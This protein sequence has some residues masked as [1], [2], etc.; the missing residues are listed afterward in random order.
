MAVSDAVAARPGRGVDGDESTFRPA[1]V[2]QAR[3]AAAFAR[4]AGFREWHAIRY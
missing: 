2:F 1:F 4:R 3:R